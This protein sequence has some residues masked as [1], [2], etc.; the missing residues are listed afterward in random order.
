MVPPFGLLSVTLGSNSC[1]QVKALVQW[2][3]LLSSRGS[4]FFVFWFES[5]DPEVSE[6]VPALLSSSGDSMRSKGYS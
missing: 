3:L 5:S 1:M 2:E 6:S 4:F